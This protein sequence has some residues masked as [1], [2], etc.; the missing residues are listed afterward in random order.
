MNKFMPFAAAALLSV[1][2][3]AHHAA[4]G[5]APEDVW[6][7]VDAILADS[8]HATMEVDVNDMSGN[9]MINPAAGNMVDDVVEELFVMLGKGYS[10]EVSMDRGY[11]TVIN[12][13]PTG[14]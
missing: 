2:A 1:N 8:P 12:V 5:V 3:Y 13:E 4:E 6:D 7:N 14:R 11:N 10:V 9:V